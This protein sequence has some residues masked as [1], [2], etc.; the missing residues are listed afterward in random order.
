[1]ELKR[2]RTLS[3][4]ALV[5]ASTLVLARPGV[6]HM[7]RGLEEVLAVERALVV[8]EDPGPP[9]RK[10]FDANFGGVSDAALGS[11]AEEDVRAYM[12]AA[13]TVAFY[14]FDP[15]YLDRVEGAFRVLER[16]GR[17]T[18]F[19]VSNMYQGYVEFRRFDTAI[20]LAA[21]HPGIEQEALPTFHGLSGPAEGPTV[22]ALQS[23][24]SIQRVPAGL[25]PVGPQVI[26]TAHPLC[27]FSDAAVRE[28][29][30]DPELEALFTNRTLW[31]MP[32][33]RRMNLD[34]VA[35][36]NRQFPD[37]AMRWAY[38]TSDWPMIK[39]WATPNFYFYRDGKLVTTVIGW[40]P[41]GQ[42]DAL[43]SAFKEI[44]VE[45]GAPAQRSR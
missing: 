10:A 41:E 4:I 26:V 24:G 35:E 39:R 7:Q 32:Q 42:R 44:G 23:D 34:V 20:A 3:C 37:Y 19:D 17:V 28:I 38:Q 25:A 6:Q 5:L 16:R 22:M 2:I 8:G 33:D 40:P 13:D 21:R 15:L 29:A 12:S 43:I 1:M 30:Q 14:T 31:L 18:S 36:W 45:R 11:L 9:L 27:H